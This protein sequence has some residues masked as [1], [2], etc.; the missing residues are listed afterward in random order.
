MSRTIYIDKNA[1]KILQES[2]LLDTVPEDI[3]NCIF[4]NQTSLK[5]NPAIPGVFEDNFIEKIVKKRFL[6]LKDN[7]KKIGNIDDFDDDKIETVLAKL[8]L[9]TQKIE[10][11]HKRIR[12]IML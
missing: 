2:I 3:M 8:I 10:Q 7:L 5:N 6:E 4:K 1:Y 11:Q 12:K 9:K